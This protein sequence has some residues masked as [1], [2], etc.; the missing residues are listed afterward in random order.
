MT[1]GD[2]IIGITE[3][4][5]WSYCAI[6]GTKFTD[7]QATGGGWRGRFLQRFLQLRI[8]PVEAEGGSSYRQNAKIEQNGSRK[9]SNEPQGAYKWFDMIANNACPGKMSLRSQIILR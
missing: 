3:R 7:L 8:S 4:R 1:K 2:A 6:W 9:S 5:S